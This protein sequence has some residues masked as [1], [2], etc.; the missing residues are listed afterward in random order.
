MYFNM[1]L[2]YNIA[3]H[4]PVVVINFL[5]MFKEATMEIF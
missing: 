3:V 5:V 4:W 2:G 1:L